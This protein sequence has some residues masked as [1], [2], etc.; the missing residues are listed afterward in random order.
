M[1]AVCFLLL[2]IFIPSREK[3]I[4]PDGPLISSGWEAAT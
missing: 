1:K 4:I 2:K 3:D